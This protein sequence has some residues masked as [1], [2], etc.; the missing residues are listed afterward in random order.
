MRR[1]PLLLLLLL[2]LALVTAA[3]TDAQEPDGAAQPTASPGDDVTD[4]PTGDPAEVHVEP[5]DRTEVEVLGSAAY[6]ENR[7]VRYTAN[8]LSVE[9]TRVERTGDGVLAVNWQVRNTADE[10]LVFNPLF[11]TA[12]VRVRGVYVADGSRQAPPLD[13]ENDDCLCVYLGEK[14]DTVG[15]GHV[16]LYR[17]VH[18]DLGTDTVTFRAGGFE[19]IPDLPVVDAPLAEPTPAERPAVVVAGAQEGVTIEV[20]PLERYDEVAV[21]RATVDNRSAEDAQL[22][23]A[24]FATEFAVGGGPPGTGAVSFVAGDHHHR[25]LTNDSNAC[26]CTSGSRVRAGDRQELTWV[27]TAPDDDV[28]HVTLS[29]PWFGAIPG[30]PVVDATEPLQL[31]LNG[32]AIDEVENAGE[33]RHRLIASIEELQDDLV[34]RVTETGGDTTD[35]AIASD[36]LFDFDADEL[37]AEADPLIDDLVAQLETAGELTD[38]VVVEGHTDA[39]GNPSYNLEL[40]ERRAASVLAAIEQRL[41]RDDLAFE[42]VGRGQDEPVADNT[43]DEGRQR[44]RRVTVRIPTGG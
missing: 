23:M 27:F 28:T 18:P 7:F 11:G 6:V 44:N 42:T 32:R 20:A 10:D 8:D 36:V 39:V 40:S 21:L 34:T 38:P 4:G 29:V 16:K 33:H 12:A 43:T 9:V 19:E 24:R 1:R 35:V 22:P 17:S 13:D 14:N 5:L 41:T 15:A 37:R 26:Y 25:V 2:A 30:V 3:C 31:E